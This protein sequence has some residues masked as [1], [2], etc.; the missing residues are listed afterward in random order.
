[1]SA[2]PFLTAHPIAGGKNNV[3]ANQ[4]TSKPALNAAGRPVE[5]PVGA[6]PITP[7]AVPIVWGT[8][9]KQFE[10][11]VGVSLNAEKW[12]N[13]MRGIEVA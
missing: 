1:V 11:Q 7:L 9:R 8:I 10:E 5:P 2:L 4:R 12:K 6:L 13:R 3:R